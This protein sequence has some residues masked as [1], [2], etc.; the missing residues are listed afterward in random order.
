VWEGMLCSPNG[1]A[2]YATNCACERKPQAVVG[3]KDNSTREFGNST[4]E[5]NL[6]YTINNGSPSAVH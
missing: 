1:K 3:Y 5:K 6:G 4:F 2:L